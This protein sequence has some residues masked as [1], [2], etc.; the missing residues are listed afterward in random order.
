MGSKEVCFEHRCCVSAGRS[1]V[2]TE[3]P[4][5]LHPLRKFSL[6]HLCAGNYGESEVRLCPCPQG[7]YE[8]SCP[9]ATTFGV[10]S[11][12]VIF[13]L[14][15]LV[16]LLIF[17]HNPTSP[18]PW[19]CFCLFLVEPL[20]MWCD[21][22]IYFLKG[23]DSDHPR[24]RGYIKRRRWIVGQ[25]QKGKNPW[26]LKNLRSFKKTGTCPHGEREEMRI[27]KRK[28]KSLHRSKK[29]SWWT[30]MKTQPWQLLG[31]GLPCPP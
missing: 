27:L 16:E 21:T 29:S 28:R 12:K 3:D 7:A 22:M 31:D 6:K 14:C 1:Q 19:C 18:T 4:S 25:W 20:D 2:D 8:A 26:T 9:P 24:S 15:F 13:I 23:N 30:E 17:I 10:L 11:E 5:L